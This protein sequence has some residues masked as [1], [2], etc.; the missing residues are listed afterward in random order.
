MTPQGRLA[1]WL[2]L[3]GAFSL[4]NY[5]SRLSEGR[6]PKDVVYQY[7]VAVGG[8]VQYA[9]ILA[10]V[11]LL[12]RGAIA[13]LLALQRPHSWG[14]AALVGLGVFAA[15]WLVAAGLDP[16]LEADREQGLTPD[17][18][19]PDRAGAFAANF[20]VIAA[21]APV[22]EELTFRGLGFSVL[23]RYG[24]VLAIAAIGLL[25]GLAHGLVY[26]LP[27][28]AVFGAGLAYL[29]SRTSSVYPGIVVHGLFNALAL[30]IAVST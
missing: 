16:V 18:W 10:I 3:V 24:R 15:V 20:I 8:L 5:V 30:T 9:I 2:S 28:L 21:V 23:E 22:V 14:R 29:R 6:P 1:G 13:R 7:S 25:F 27:I 26:G 19:R 17:R 12:A 4:L 11:L